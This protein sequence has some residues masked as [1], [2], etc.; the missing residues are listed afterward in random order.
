[1]NEW[2]YDADVASIARISMSDKGGR[3]EEVQKNRHKDENRNQ[4]N[5]NLEGRKSSTKKSE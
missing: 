2:I 5:R 1:M 4:R 3:G